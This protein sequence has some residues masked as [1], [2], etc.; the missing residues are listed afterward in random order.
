[1]SQEG[2]EKA[3]PRTSRATKLTLAAVAI[4]LLLAVVCFV[5]V[6]LLP[7]PEGGHRFKDPLRSLVTGLGVLGVATP[8]C[9]AGHALKKRSAASPY[10]EGT[11]IATVLGVFGFLG[12]AVGLACIILGGYDWITAM[13]D[14]RP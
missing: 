8:L 11:F 5:I 12:L 13:L 10:F 1:V 9:I 6:A 3:T 14:S 7:V 2:T 4:S